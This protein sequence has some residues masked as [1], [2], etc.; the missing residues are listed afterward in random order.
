M[1]LD[2]RRPAVFI[3]TNEDHHAFFTAT[4]ARL[5]RRHYRYEVENNPHG[6][7]ATQQLAHIVYVEFHDS[8][9]L[10]AEREKELDKL[11]RFSKQQLIQKY[12]PTWE[13][14]TAY[15]PDI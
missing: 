14:L 12:N 6:P 2:A 15:L 4:S 13:D 5:T 3:R 8:L 9:E 1:Q 11:P 7:V 10:C